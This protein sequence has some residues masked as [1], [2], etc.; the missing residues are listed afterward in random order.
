MACTDLAQSRFNSSIQFKHHREA[1]ILF[2]HGYPSPSSCWFMSDFYSLPVFTLLSLM[3]GGNT[4]AQDYSYKL[5]LS[6]NYCFIVETAAFLLLL[7]SPEFSDS[8]ISHASIIPH[9]LRLPAFLNATCH[10]TQV[11]ICQLS[12][13]FMFNFILFTIMQTLEVVSF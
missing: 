8:L 2:K 4:F 11:D 13:G 12:K 9:S 1:T 5:L 3:K 6:L 10:Y 7:P